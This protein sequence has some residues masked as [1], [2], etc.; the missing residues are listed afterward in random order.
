MVIFVD[1]QGTPLD[2]SWASKE[3][4]LTVI[5]GPQCFPRPRA[6]RFA[7]SSPGDDVTC[8]HSEIAAV[9]QWAK[10]SIFMPSSHALFVASHF[11]TR[12]FY[13]YTSC[14]VGDGGAGPR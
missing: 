13:E 1:T 2:T 9:I 12:V 7:H 3:S 10:A 5:H 11:L 4:Q 14:I 6:V 8:L